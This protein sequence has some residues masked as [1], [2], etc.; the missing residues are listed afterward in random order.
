MNRRDFLGAGKS[1]SADQLSQSTRLVSTGLKPYTGVW[2]NNEVI[3]LLKRTMFGATVQV[4]YEFLTR[5]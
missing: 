3:H 2:T 5:K 1:K 4:I